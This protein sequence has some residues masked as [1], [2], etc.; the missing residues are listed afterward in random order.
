M[1]RP[2][3]HGLTKTKEYSV[4]LN[5][6]RR[7]AD[8]KHWNF[9]YY[10]GKGVRVCSEWMDDPRP[11]VAWLHSQG[12]NPNLS[13]DR[14]DGNGDYS[15]ENCRLADRKTQCRN[16]AQTIFATIN[17]KRRALREWAEIAGIK[18]DTVKRRF[19]RGDRG[20]RLIRKVS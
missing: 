19:Y 7:C 20:E 4:W 9:Q 1:A 8:P 10:G 2:V 5:M 12:W 18:G 6:R 11:F 3:V 17:G 16:Q 15:P 13:I 14:V